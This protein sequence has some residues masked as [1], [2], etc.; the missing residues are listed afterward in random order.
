[1]KGYLR[2]EENKSAA[3]DSMGIAGTPPDLGNV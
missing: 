2:D 3:L 1:M